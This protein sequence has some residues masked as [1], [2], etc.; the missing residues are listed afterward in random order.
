VT[1]IIL[2]IPDELKV[3]ETPVRALCNLVAGRWSTRW[4]QPQSTHGLRSCRAS[5][6]LGNVVTLRYETAALGAV[7]TTER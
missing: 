6:G 5:L 7:L 1:K 2:E 3:P 4:C